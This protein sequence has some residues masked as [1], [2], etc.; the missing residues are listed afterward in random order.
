MKCLHSGYSNNSTDDMGD[1]LR[2]MDPNSEILAS[3]NMKKTKA[4]YVVN[5]GLAPY[6]R[7]MLYDTLAV[8]KERSIW[9]GCTPFSSHLCCDVTACT[10]RVIVSIE[11]LVKVSFTKCRLAG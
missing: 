4:A 5:H 3:F 6:Y 2:R 11:E 1:V 10:K 8:G 7:D 9:T